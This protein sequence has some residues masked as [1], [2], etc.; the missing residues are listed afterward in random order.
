MGTNKTVGGRK[1]TGGGIIRSFWHTTKLN[2]AVRGGSDVAAALAQ[3]RT[4]TREQRIKS[5]RAG[6]GKVNKL[7]V[8]AK[9]KFE[10]R[11]VDH[12]T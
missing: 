7:Y 5:T 2:L 9:R 12:F 4:R 6:R 8:R 3:R 1:G 10:I 11:P